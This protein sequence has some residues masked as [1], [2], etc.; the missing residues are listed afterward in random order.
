MFVLLTFAVWAMAFYYNQLIDRHFG[1]EDRLIARSSGGAL[2]EFILTHETKFKYVG[3][4]IFW[5]GLNSLYLNSVAF[6]GR[7]AFIAWATTIVGLLSYMAAS[8]W[9]F[10]WRSK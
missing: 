10:Y 5:V 8:C 1:E 3:L 6:S 4:F 7:F 2:V 9:L